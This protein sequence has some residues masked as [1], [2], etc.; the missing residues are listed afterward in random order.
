[1]GCMGGECLQNGTIGKIWGH[2]DR[3][4]VVEWGQIWGG[5]RGVGRGVMKNTAVTEV[6]MLVIVSVIL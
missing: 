3:C 2:N 1:M 5:L 4:G 6:L